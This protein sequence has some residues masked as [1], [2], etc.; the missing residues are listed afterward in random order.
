MLNPPQISATLVKGKARIKF[1]SK[2]GKSYTL[3]RAMFS[4]SALVATHQ[5][6]GENNMPKIHCYL[7]LCMY[8]CMYVCMYEFCN[9]L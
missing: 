3:E 2:E 5:K 8:V 7:C 4:Y 9:L 1:S 6:K